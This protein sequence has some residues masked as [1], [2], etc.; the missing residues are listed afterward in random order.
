MHQDGVDNSL[1]LLKIG[2]VILGGFNN[3]ANRLDTADGCQ[4]RLSIVFIEP[5]LDESLVLRGEV[6]GELYTVGGNIIL[7]DC[8]EVT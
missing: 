4:R 2:L 6:G 5:H 7:E 1:Q 3:S 8:H